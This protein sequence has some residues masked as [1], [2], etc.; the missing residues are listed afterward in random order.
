MQYDLSECT[1]EDADIMEA[2]E[3][4]LKGIAFNAFNRGLVTG[5][6]PAIVDTWS[7]HVAQPIPSGQHAMK[8][9]H[10]GEEYLVEWSID[11]TAQTPHE[12]AS[13][14]LDIQRDAASTATF[15]EVT[16]TRGQRHQIDLMQMDVS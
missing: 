7:A 11:I 5:D 9:V 15:F 10:G 8:Q 13:R 1:G 3:R 2:L 14:A 6:L 4:N 16:D 12:A